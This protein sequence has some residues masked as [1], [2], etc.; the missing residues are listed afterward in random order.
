MSQPVPTPDVT[1]AAYEADPKKPWKALV[2]IIFG[3]LYAVFEA[4][5]I[6]LGDGSWDNDDTT[7]VVVALL[8]A[9]VV[10]LTRNPKIAERG[11]RRI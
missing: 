6:A 9:V 11:A 4:V 1:P 8:S 5:Q 3:I 7:A 10:F 2:P